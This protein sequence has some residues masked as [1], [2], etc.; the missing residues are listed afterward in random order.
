MLRFLQ[1][2]QNGAQFQFFSGLRPVPHWGA[3]NAPRPPADFLAS[4]PKLADSLRSFTSY[5]CGPPQT[6]SPK[7]PQTISAATES[8]VCFLIFSTFWLS[9]VIFS[10]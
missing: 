1:M 8:E 10:I 6:T 3:Y 9:L 2:S 5:A 7:G 4:Q